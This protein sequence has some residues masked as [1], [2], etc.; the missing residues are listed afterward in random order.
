[1]TTTALRFR[2]HEEFHRAALHM[3]GAGALAGLIGW[4]SLPGASP[5]ALTLVAGAAAVAALAPVLRNE[6]RQLLGRGLLVALGGLCLM[7]APR[8]GHAAALLGFASLFGLALAWG[9]RGRTLAL[10]IAGGGALALVA[11]YCF[12]SIVTAQELASLPGWAT[13]A[14]GGAAFSLVA[15]VALL[16]RHLQVARDPVAVAH[17]DLRGG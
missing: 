11:R 3:V 10:A 8:A 16:P 14:M 2:N 17:R 6:G 1:M 15:A 9:L 5:W 4:A 12:A 13:A 7:L